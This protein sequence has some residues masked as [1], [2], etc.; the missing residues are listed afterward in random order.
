[1]RNLS[2]AFWLF[3][4]GEN[5]VNRSAQ[6]KAMRHWISYVGAAALIRLTFGLLARH[7]SL[8]SNFS[9]LILLLL[10]WGNPS[11]AQTIGNFFNIRPDCDYFDGYVYCSELVI[12]TMRGPETAGLDL[13]NL[14]VGERYIF[15]FDFEHFAISATGSGYWNVEIVGISTTRTQSISYS[16]NTYTQSI[17]FTA[18]A[19]THRLVFTPFS[20]VMTT[21]LGARATS[22]V[23]DAPRVTSVSSS[24]ANGHYKAGDVISVDV[25]PSA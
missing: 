17:S 6:R 12:G 1:M 14:V 22:L 8:R 25:A 24:T 11:A 19:S 21:Y 7:R 15:T 23:V 3:F 10:S 20:D 16:P 9:I 13:T 4:K 5:A 18:T 2:V